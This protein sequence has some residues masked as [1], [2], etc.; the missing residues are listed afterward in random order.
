[1][2]HDSHE[3]RPWGCV[4]A[5]VSVVAFPMV[6]SP[7]IL[8]IVAFMV[9]VGTMVSCALMVR[10]STTRDLSYFHKKIISEYDFAWLPIDLSYKGQSYR[11]HYT[12][13]RCQSSKPV[14]IIMHGAYS[15]S[16]PFLDLADAMSNDYT[17][18]VLD[19]PGWGLSDGPS[20]KDL[21]ASDIIELHSQMLVQFMNSHSI[22]KAV[23]LAHSLCG[24]FS[25]CFAS[26]YPMRVEK[27]V[28]MNPAG[29]FSTLGDSG[30]YWALLFKTG[31]HNRL[32]RVL[33][34][35]IIPIVSI[36]TS[37]SHVMFHLNLLASPMQNVELLPKFI[38]STPHL[39]GWLRPCFSDL[40]ALD[41]P[42]ALI[43]GANDGLVP[44]HQG[45]FLSFL[46]HN[47]L[48]CVAVRNA[49]HAPHAVIPAFLG[50]LQLALKKAVRPSSV[51]DASAIESTKAT[52]GRFV[53]TFS[54]SNTR[55]KV[56]KMYQQ[57][58]TEFGMCMPLS[59]KSLEEL[60]IT[61]L[62]HG[63]T[64]ASGLH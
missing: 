32:L 27:L 15:S 54:L 16:V 35:F 63:L 10:G 36:L 2:L 60:A 33:R 61:P 57:I 34:P 58:A 40:L 56:I 50:A 14:A 47:R 24:F 46:S 41:V 59:Y 42:T 13:K 49:K 7:I 38:T 48:P 1:M 17:T 39:S 22:D 23:V 28:L 64:G 12:T 21:S 8:A 55:Q 62:G 43:Y 51:F 37:S 9:H 29:I 6:L 45:C 18:Y 26:Q 44:L 20:L 4:L 11:M 19:I 30:A 52:V 5:G 25:V 3:W 53:T 31:F